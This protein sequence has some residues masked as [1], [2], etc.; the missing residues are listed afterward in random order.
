MDAY[1]AS[2]DYRETS[3]LFFNLNFEV[4]KGCQFSCKGCAVNKQEAQVLAA[5][6]KEKLIRLLDSVNDDGIY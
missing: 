4:L 2:G 3:S 6:D 1:L 5:D